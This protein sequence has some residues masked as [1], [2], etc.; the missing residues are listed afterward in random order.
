MGSNGTYPLINYTSLTGGNST[1]N[2]TFAV[3]TT[4]ASVSGRAFN[5]INTGANVG[6]VD[7]T[8]TS[9]N[10]LAL[11][12]TFNRTSGTLNGSSPTIQ[13]GTAGTWTSDGNWT[14]ATTGGG[15]AAI[16]VTSV[17]DSFYTGMGITPAAG[18]IYVLSATL[19]PTSGASN[20]DWLAMGFG[21][22]G[23]TASVNATSTMAWMLERV[24]GAGRGILGRRH[25]L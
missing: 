6:A 15:Q 11:Q 7:V 3:G 21:T 22:A 8:V 25:G 13:N 9:L 18:K 2:N 24:S 20:S 17:T 19:D 5:F 23:T 16:S 10:P 4:P 1:F 12:D 14:T